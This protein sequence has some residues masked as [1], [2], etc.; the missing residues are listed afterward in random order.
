MG[1]ILFSH[2]WRIIGGDIAASS[3]CFMLK[4]TVQLGKIVFECAAI[5][6]PLFY[7]LFFK[8]YFSLPYQKHNAQGPQSYQV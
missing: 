2:W 6:P 8:I 5:T 7:F 1:Y 4:V 3:Q